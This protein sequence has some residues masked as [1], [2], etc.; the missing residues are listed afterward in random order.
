[1]S[2]ITA[3]LKQLHQW[4]DETNWITY[5]DMEEMLIQAAKETL[6]NGLPQI[7]LRREVEPEDLEVRTTLYID[8]E[9]LTSLDRDDVATLRALL[10]AY[11][12]T[13]PARVGDPL[14]MPTR[15]RS[16]KTVSEVTEELLKE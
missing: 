10:L 8:G 6:P 14:S 15:L 1:M 16:G 4:Q 7:T 5:N 9:Y 13:I 11:D 3:M 12:E 2:F